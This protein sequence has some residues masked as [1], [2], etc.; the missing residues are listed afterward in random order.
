MKTMLL[1]FKLVISFIFPSQKKKKLCWNLRTIEF[2]RKSSALFSH[3]PSEKIGRH[4][5]PVRRFPPEGALNH[6]V[7]HSLL[8]KHFLQCAAR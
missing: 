4:N 5:G 8:Y 3:M 1:H 6:R 7:H 2:L